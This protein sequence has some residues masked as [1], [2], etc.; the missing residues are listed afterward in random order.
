MS[1]GWGL[2]ALTALLVILVVGV[3]ALVFSADE[4]LPTCD[5]DECSERRAR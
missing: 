4:W 2:A 5:C 3:T 1:A